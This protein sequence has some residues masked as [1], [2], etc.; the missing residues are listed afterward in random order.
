MTQRYA[1]HF[2]E[3]GFITKD[4]K[5]VVDLTKLERRHNNIVN[6]EILTQPLKQEIDMLT[7]QVKTQGRLI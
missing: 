4:L 2:E 1:S 5:G 7:I 6:R 3:Q